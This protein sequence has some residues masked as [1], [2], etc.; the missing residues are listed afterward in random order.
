M[1]RAI[2]IVGAA[3]FFGIAIAI[4]SLLAAAVSGTQPAVDQTTILVLPFSAP[5][6][7]SYQW[8]GRAIQQDLLTDLA[9]GTRTR[10]IAPAGA[11]PVADA[12]AARRTG[13]Q[14]G[15][16]MV[17]F[18]QVQAAGSELRL[19]GQVIDVSTAQPLA[20]L[21]ATGSAD[22]LFHLEDALAGQTLAA[23]PPNLV[24]A[25][26]LQPQRPE[27]S[28]PDEGA[29]AGTYPSTTQQGA[30]AAPPSS[31]G[32]SYAPEPSYVYPSTTTY[33]Y[34]Y[35]QPVPVYTYPYPAFEVFPLASAFIF[36]DVDH[37]DHFHHFGRDFDHDGDI[38]NIPG[39]DFDHDFVDVHSGDPMAHGHQMNRGPAGTGRT[40][41]LARS[42][43]A[44][45][46]LTR[47]QLARSGSA[48]AGG[49]RSG[50]APRPMGGAPRAGSG[51]MGGFHGRPGAGR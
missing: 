14:Q 7:G 33:S 28:P 45:S 50:V 40:P 11:S 19:T 49:M 31:G 32:A 21:K 35:Y 47:P 44:P 22:S 25:Q 51:G 15:A 13:Q 12:D 2:G 43:P 39:R 23:L 38:D 20:N 5:A 30:Y 17:M 26:A 48:Q 18:G 29:A 10:V 42:G 37:F 4:P 9:Q 8:V 1:S 16:S 24:N 6:G 46:P 34:T 27:K 41:G 36:I 3:V